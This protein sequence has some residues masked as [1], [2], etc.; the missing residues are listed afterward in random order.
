MTSV[1]DTVKM[2]AIRD[3]GKNVYHTSPTYWIE[4]AE[5]LLRIYKGMGEDCEIVTIEIKP[6]KEK[7]NE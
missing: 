5:G 2:F 3:V 1:T 6:Y 7:K 4:K